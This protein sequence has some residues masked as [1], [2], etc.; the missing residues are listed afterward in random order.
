MNPSQKY[1]EFLQQSGFHRDPVQQHVIYLLNRL[2]E[3]VESSFEQ[4]D[5]VFAAILSIFPK[6]TR[7]LQGLYIWGGVGRGKTFLM[8][9]FFQSLALK[10]KK[11]LHFHQFMKFIHDELRLSRK[12]KDPIR[13]IARAF[14]TNT[15]VL[16]LDEFVVTDIGDAMLTGRLLKALFDEGVVLVTTSNI[17]PEALYKD[18]LQRA[19]FLP[20]IDLLLQHC[21]ITNLDGG[22]DYR[23]LGFKQTQV[24]QYPHDEKTHDAIQHFLKTHLLSGQQHEK[25]IINDR[26]IIFEYCA[27]DTIWFAFDELCKT[28]RSRLDYL[29]I[30]QTFNTLVI[31]GIEQMGNHCNDV[32]RRFISLI[33]VLYDHRVKLICSAAV[34]VEEL[35]PQ[36]FLHFEFQRTVSRL[37]EMQNRDY[38]GLSHRV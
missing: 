5:N 30:A 16:C 1:D 29:E 21:Q 33:D 8:D 38:M 9:I 15:R 23:T 28:A 34:A 10:Q 19:N 26:P 37:T 22:V 17:P 25:L 20:T 4:D 3:E 36:G 7:T 27:E 14:A 18:G 12:G 6:R 31:T 35:Y 2:H 11:R 32:A 24:Y 13:E